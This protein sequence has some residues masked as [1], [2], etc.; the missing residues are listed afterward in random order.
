MSTIIELLK[1]I[2]AKNKLYLTTGI[3]CFF[4]LIWLYID[5]HSPTGTTL[6]PIKH[7]TG[8]PC[9]SCGTTRSVKSLLD[10]DIMQA[11]MINPLGLLV[12]ILAIGIIVLM[13]IDLIFQ[14]DYFFRAYRWI[15][16]TLQKQRLLSI[17]L[18]LFILLNWIWNIKKG[19]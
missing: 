2:S 14:K 15:E 10:G 17:I 16:H 5:Y 8:Y 4:G 19:L 7:V 3:V 13:L 6:C 18:I 12:S 1:T 9:P 11:I